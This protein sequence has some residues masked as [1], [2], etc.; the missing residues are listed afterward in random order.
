[1]SD[2]VYNS[3][4]RLTLGLLLAA[5]TPFTTAVAQSAD[6]DP[7]PAPP[8]AEG[9]GPFERLIIRGAILI[10]GTGAPP[11]G[12]VDIVVEGNRIISIVNTEAV[13]GMMR[14]EGRPEG[15]E[16]YYADG[17]VDYARRTRA[18][19]FQRGIQ[20]LEDR[21]DLRGCSLPPGW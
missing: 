14:A 7:R 11:R 20:R 2:V 16:F 10:D 21:L 1:M 17:H 18:P 9:D 3:M 8:R 4:R 13:A 5:A 6:I 19:D 12:P 15:A